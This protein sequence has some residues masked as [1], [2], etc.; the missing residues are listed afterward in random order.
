MLTHLP[1]E[2]MRQ[3]YFNL[4]TE[5]VIIVFYNCSFIDRHYN[6]IMEYTPFLSEAEYTCLLCV[7]TAVDSLLCAAFNTISLEGK[8][9]NCFRQQ[10]HQFVPL[11]CF[12]KLGFMWNRKIIVRS[13]MVISVYNFIILHQNI[14]QELIPMLVRFNPKSNIVYMH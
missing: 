13:S 14:T 8:T 10:N 1:S 11:N 2:L 12:N 3:T 9:P 7:F 6:D 5:M 4:L